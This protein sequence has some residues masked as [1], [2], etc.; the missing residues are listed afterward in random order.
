MLSAIIGKKNCPQFTT[1]YAILVI[2][3]LNYFENNYKAVYKYDNSQKK[4]PT[5]SHDFKDMG[6]SQEKF[7]LYT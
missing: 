7:S 5:A 4:I 1:I 6:R 2:Y 3:L